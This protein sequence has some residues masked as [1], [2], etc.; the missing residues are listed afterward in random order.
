MRPQRRIE[1][2]RLSIDFHV[3]QVLKETPLTA[4]PGLAAPLAV[5]SPEATALDLVEFNHAIGGM[6]RAME[7][8]ESVT[9]KMT[10]A[11]WRRALHEEVPVSVLQ[12]LGYVLMLLKLE[13]YAA[14]VEK[15][16]PSRLNS[17][18]LQTRS[19]ASKSRPKPITP[20]H[21]VENVDLRSDR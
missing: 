18:V 2:G 15:S 7:V 8:I 10:V 5:S 12:R 4:L 16:L 14:M 21:I 9:P 6:R 3:K 17:T 20:F 13:S 1:L 11:G 19:P